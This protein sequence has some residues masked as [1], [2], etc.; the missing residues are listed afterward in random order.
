MDEPVPGVFTRPPGPPL[1]RF[2]R[3]HVGSEVEL[4][5]GG[6]GGL[7]GSRGSPASEEE[8]RALVGAMRRQGLTPHPFGTDHDDVFLGLYACARRRREA[9]EAG[10]LELL[11]GLEDPP[12]E[13]RRAL[14][15]PAVELGSGEARVRPLASTGIN[16]PRCILNSDRDNE[17]TAEIYGWF[18]EVICDL[19][20]VGCGVIRQFTRGDLLWREI[21]D[22]GVIPPPREVAEALAEDDYA[23]LSRF[24]SVVLLCW[25]LGVKLVPTLFTFG[26]GSKLN[27]DQDTATWLIEDEVSY[28]SLRHAAPSDHGGLVIPS[29]R[30]WDA[31]YYDQDTLGEYR[32]SPSVEGGAD[33]TLF[34]RYCLSLL[35][36]PH[37]NN[38]DKDSKSGVLYLRESARRKSLAV[39]MFGL[40]VGRFLALLDTSIRGATDAT[41][42]TVIP[43]LEC[44]NEL[45]AFWAK[46]GDEGKDTPRSALEF[47][48]F[49]ALLSTTVKTLVP[50]LPIRAGELRSPPDPDQWPVAQEWLRLS[51]SEGLPRE[52]SF[53]ETIQE[54]W[55]LER[56]GSSLSDAVSDFVEVTAWIAEHPHAVAWMQTCEE[57][58]VYWPP[59]EGS[60]G[61][62]ASDLV[63]EVGFHWYHFADEG[64]PEGWA[65]GDS[66]LLAQVE[67][68][69]EDPIEPLEGEGFRLSWS[70]SEVGYPAGHPEVST[71][72]DD[73]RALVYAS[74]A[75][76]LVQAG[77]LWR[78]LLL[79]RATGADHVLWQT[80]MSTVIEREQKWTQFTTLG[81]RDD[82]TGGSP[83]REWQTRGAFRRSSWYAYRRL[84]W[85]LSQT[86]R[87]RLLSSDDGAFLVK[88]TSMEGGYGSPEG[89]AFRTWRYA[90]VAWV[91]E[92]AGVDEATFEL[93]DSS[94]TGFR[95][96]HVAPA[97]TEPMPIPSSSEA[98]GALDSCGYIE[99]EFL[100]WPFGSLTL[101][102]VRSFAGTITLNPYRARASN[103]LPVCV[104]TNASGRGK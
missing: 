29:L 99:G 94:G 96:L 85:L 22:D 58:G 51:L 32:G 80:H 71:V 30:G 35:G 73:G 19:T 24:S 62:S 54:G 40:E 74:E 5:G 37:T 16:R 6:T 7:A 28:E 11:A 36:P 17:A 82:F 34:A 57:A 104:L 102:E 12:S 92:R 45:D 26:G 31:F 55:A 41:L 4:V 43:V 84:A 60:L 97:V 78:R 50:S 15:L 98:S 72:D 83:N 44:G 69:Q 10:D 20:A 75:T 27:D 3:V 56:S 86:R 25:A 65:L 1:A 93:R 18:W 21:F 91:D 42:E 23:A 103:P 67:G 66:D 90:Y 2:G 70:V 64:V 46:G 79:L 63:Q 39:A 81:L 101:R 59:T 38:S 88:L 48:R 76:A 33:R 13:L 49:I 8:L 53:Y 77:V 95:Q 100:S 9:V 47:S 89:A 68:W 52:L 14:G 61:W 87:V